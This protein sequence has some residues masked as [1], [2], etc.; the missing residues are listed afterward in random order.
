MPELTHPYY[1]FTEAGFQVDVASI[2]GGMAPVESK[3][4]E[5]EDEFHDRFINDPVLMAKVIRSPPLSEANPN[6]YQTIM[7]GGGSGPMWDLPNNP[8]ISW[9]SAAI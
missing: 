5:E 9:V 2:S 4:F 3:A 7:F 6:Y 1:E 8:D